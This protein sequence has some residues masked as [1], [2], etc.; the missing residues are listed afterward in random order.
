MRVPRASRV[1]LQQPGF[2]FGSS[3]ADTPSDAIDLTAIRQAAPEGGAGDFER[4]PEAEGWVFA[5]ADVTAS[6]LILPHHRLV[7]CLARVGLFGR[8]TIVRR[9][10][11]AQLHLDQPQ[12]TQLRQPASRTRPG[13]LH[14]GHSGPSVV[15]A[16]PVDL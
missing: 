10:F 7:G 1:C 11:G 2:G 3:N 5:L 15:A 6:G 8:P 4:R 12:W 14:F 13:W 16:L 9:L